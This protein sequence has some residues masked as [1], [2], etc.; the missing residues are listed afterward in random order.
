MDGSTLGIR[1]GEMLK[2]WR[3]AEELNG[4]AIRRVTSLWHHVTAI[5]NGPACM[6][7]IHAHTADATMI[8]YT[9]RRQDRELVRRLG[10]IHTGFG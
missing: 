2:R 3:K 1:S 9:L 10:G 7:V 6:Y 4:E 5:V 8:H